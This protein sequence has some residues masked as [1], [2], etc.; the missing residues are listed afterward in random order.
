ME[1]KSVSQESISS[2]LGLFQ[3]GGSMLDTTYQLPVLPSSI[4]IWSRVLPGMMLPLQAIRHC[5]LIKD[6]DEDNIYAA[7][8][9]PELIGKGAV[10]W[11]YQPKNNVILTTHRRLAQE[12][13][14]QGKRATIATFTVGLVHSEVVSELEQHSAQLLEQFMAL[15]KQGVTFH[16]QKCTIKDALKALT[17][18]IEKEV[19]AFK[20][21]IVTCKSLRVALELVNITGRA[22]A[23]L[24][25]NH[26]HTLG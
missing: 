4:T 22:P 26:T 2:Q 3:T 20:N 10:D 23:M 13:M 14:A 12:L 5:Y 17:S 15:M 7:L 24:T 18:S 11:E 19:V 1:T 6:I 9:L 25:R 21:G 16:F 8:V